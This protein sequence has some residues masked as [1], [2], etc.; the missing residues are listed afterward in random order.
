MMEQ[1]P[2]IKVGV[3]R[4]YPVVLIAGMLFLLGFNATH[5]QTGVY[6][7]PTGSD[8]TGTGAIDN[9]YRTFRHAITQAADWDTV[10]AL[11]GTYFEQIAV[12]YSHPVHVAGYEGAANTTV[13]GDFAGIVFDYQGLSD[14]P[15]ARVSLIGLTIT[16]GQPHGVQV[17]E[18]DVLI[19]D[20]VIEDCQTELT[21]GNYLGAGIYLLFSLAEIDNCT[22]QNNRA[23]FS[24]DSGGGI[25]SDYSAPLIKN[26]RILNNTADSYGGGVYFRQNIF[27]NHAPMIVNSIV[28]DNTAMGGAG[29]T[30]DCWNVYVINNII[31]GNIGGEYASGILIQYYSDCRTFN[32]IIAFNSQ[33]GMISNES[34]G[35]LSGYNCYYSNGGSDYYGG[36]DFGYNQLVD[37]QFVDYAAGDYH[38]KES[39]PLINGGY[40]LDSLPAFDF[41]EQPRIVQNDVDIG[42]DEF[43]DCSMTVNFGANPTSG[44][45][46]MLVNF[47][48]T[49]VGLYDSL[50]WDFGDGSFSYNTLNVQKPYSEVGT[51]TVTLYAITPCT[52]V[53]AVAP[54]LIVIGEPPTADFSVDVDSGCAPLL[55]QF[56]DLSLGNAT[57]WLWNFGDGTTSVL[58]TPSHEYQA[59]GIYTVRLI[60]SNVCDTDTIIRTNYITVRGSAEADFLATMTAGSAPFTADFVDQSR[61]DPTEW[62]WD[63]G[64]GGSSV[65]QNPTHEYL[66]PGLYDVQLTVTNEC[67]LFDTWLMEDYIRVYG[68]DVKL[69]DTSHTRYV[70][71][72]SFDLDSLYGQFD[73]TV[74]LRAVL[75]DPP[76]RGTAIFTLD[77]STMSVGNSSSFQAVLSKD[78][79]HGIHN[80][81]LIATAAGG[82]PRDTLLFEFESTPI[83]L[84]A[85]SADSVEFDSTQ[86]GSTAVINLIVTNQSALI[87][88][89]NLNVSSIPIDGSDA[90]FVMPTAFTVFPTSSTP[91]QIWFTPPDTG[92]YSADITIMSDDPVMSEYVVHL[93]GLGIPE[94]VPPFVDYTDPAASATGVTLT[95]VIDLVISEPLDTLSLPEGPLL[96][97]S[98]RWTGSTIDGR[99]EF[100]GNLP[101]QWIV[102]FVPDT[103]LPPLDLI[104]V[105]LNGD[106]VDLAGNSLDGDLDGVAE[107]SPIDDAVFQFE[108]GPGVYPG[109]ANNDGVVNEVDVLPLG[110]FWMMTGPDR[111]GGTEWRIQPAEV[112]TDLAATYADCNGDS[113]VNMQDLLVVAINWGNTHDYGSPQFAPGDYD[114]AE[115]QGAFEAIFFALG[116]S[117]ESEFTNSVRNLIAKYVEVETVPGQYMLSQ[118]FPNPFN[119]TTYIQFNLPVDGHVSLTVHNI[120]GQTVA[121]LVDEFQTQGFKQ[122]IWNG[123]SDAGETLPSGMYFYRMKAGTFTQVKKMLMIR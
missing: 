99:T 102:R 96:T 104:T 55:V 42:P 38:L 6:L 117:Q 50:M 66:V 29:I 107:G 80:G 35:A 62:D 114:L 71:T 12:D 88:N 74:T 24:G 119:P 83:Q 26:C 47:T 46:F 48:G 30:V 41:E 109:D 106:V 54:D 10:V 75:L 56:S 72:F 59:G 65:L 8:A 68:F 57:N 98:S 61:N 44:C 95:E 67:E 82:S 36:N 100:I 90:F 45:E 18:W 122:V 3:M 17:V 34:T 39:S 93:E 63:F 84:V 51:Y 58:P 86:I 5:G 79:W 123:T 120:L 1:K 64:D 37:P 13:S 105:T 110:V 121:T 78:L 69:A 103:I 40:F 9:P 49:V 111:P 116:E 25:F 101:H 77:D 4:W 23:T 28:R 112:W 52:T 73:R 94:R 32:N 7:S 2:R 19:R 14:V 76:Q 31:A 11:P 15:T 113:T 33:D 85:I 43:A 21:E 97:V 118:N 27:G 20:C 91:I 87:D 70:K 115:Y 92:Y 16:R 108:T 60:V 53:M 22:I 81:A 89:L